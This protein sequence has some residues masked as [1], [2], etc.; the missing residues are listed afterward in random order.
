MI[1]V[2]HNGYVY[3]TSENKSGNAQPLDPMHEISRGITCR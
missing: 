1:I 3:I 2:E